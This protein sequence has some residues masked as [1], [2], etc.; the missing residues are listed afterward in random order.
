VTKEGQEKAEL[1]AERFLEDL[2]QNLFATP[3]EKDAAKNRRRALRAVKDGPRLM[4]LILRRLG[5]EWVSPVRIPAWEL[6]L[7]LGCDGD[8]GGHTRVEDAIRALRRFEYFLNSESGGEPT[9]GKAEG[10]F[11]LRWEYYGRGP[12]RHT[13]GDFSLHVSPAFLG[14]LAVFETSSHKLKPASASV[15]L[16]FGRKLDEAER[17]KLDYVR[18]PT[19]LL[20]MYDQAAG[21]T[22]SQKRLLR[23]LERELTRQNDATRHKELF[24]PRSTEPRVYG[25]EFC[26][27][28]PKGRK[29]HG[30][31]GHYKANHNPEAGRKLKGTKGRPTKKSGARH[32]GLL[33]AMGYTLPPGRATMKRKAVLAAALEDLEGYRCRALQGRVDNGGGGPL[34]PGPRPG[35][36]RPLVPVPRRQLG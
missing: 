25:H 28:L 7:A 22:Q 35:G 17:K 33:A 27:L 9:L 24:V 21:F 26:P 15:F 29:F 6:R 34:P 19:A 36:E 2:E 20:P 5:S 23:F 3:R 8:E 31:L 4:D 16:D 1:E 12:G 11:L 13:D 18:S 30:A 10:A 32:E 14:S